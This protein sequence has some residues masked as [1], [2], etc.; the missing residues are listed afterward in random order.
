MDGGV[1]LVDDDALFRKLTERILARAGF[2]VATAG[3]SEE[4]IALSSSRSFDV[5][6]ID[7]FLG[8]KDCGCNIIA[9]LRARSPTVKVIVVSGLSLL[10]DLGR[11]AYAMGA[12]LVEGKTGVDWIKLARGE[13]IPPPPVRPAVDVYAMK[14]Q[15]IH[16]AYLVHHRNMSSTAR[17][18][19]IRRSNLQR[20]LRKTPPPIPPELTGD[21]PL[22]PQDERSPTTTLSAGPRDQPGEEPKSNLGKK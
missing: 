13:H 21:E 1:L 2:R 9:P 22:D 17:A 4:A 8:P 6:L 11:H 14:R 10:P 20:L 12:D 3:S 16:G 18:L 5:A 19:G 7:Y 15:A